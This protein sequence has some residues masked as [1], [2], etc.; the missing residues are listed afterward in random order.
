[1][2]TIGRLEVANFTQWG[3]VADPRIQ[4]VSTVLPLAD[5]M[6]GPNTPTNGLIVEDPLNDLVDRRI[7]WYPYGD[8]YAS[9]YYKRIIIKAKVALNGGVL[10]ATRADDRIYGYYGGDF[11]TAKNARILNIKYSVNPS[12]ENTPWTLHPALNTG[13]ALYNSIFRAD[14]KVKTSDGRNTTLS[15]ACNIQEGYKRQGKSTIGDTIISLPETQTVA[16]TILDFGD[17]NSVAPLWSTYCGIYPE[18]NTRLFPAASRVYEDQADTWIMRCFFE[19][20]SNERYVYFWIVVGP[21]FCCKEDTPPTDTYARRHW[22]LDTSNRPS[23]R[24]RPFETE[25]WGTDA[26]KVRIYGP[27]AC[28]FNGEYSVDSTSESGSAGNWVTTIN[29]VD[30]TQTAAKQQWI[31]F[32][33][34]HAIMGCLFFDD[35]NFTLTDS[36]QAVHEALFNGTPGLPQDS[37]VGVGVSGPTKRGWLEHQLACG[38][39]G[40]VADIPGS[41]EGPPTSLFG[42]WINGDYDV[43]HVNACNIAH[44][45]VINQQNNDPYAY[46]RMFQK[47]CT[48]DQGQF[49]ASRFWHLFSTGI[50]DTREILLSAPQNFTIRGTCYMEEDG[51]IWN[52]KNHNTCSTIAAGNR[53]IRP[54]GTP[55]GDID[56]AQKLSCVVLNAAD[57]VNLGVPMYQHSLDGFGRVRRQAWPNNTGPRTR[58]TNI[59]GTPWAEYGNSHRMSTPVI[60]AAQLCGDPLTRFIIIPAFT[61]S[62]LTCRSPVDRHGYDALGNASSVKGWIVYG[63]NREEGRFFESVASV[64]YL[65]GDPDILQALSRR[66]NDMY[67]SDRGPEYCGTATIQGDWPRGGTFGYRRYKYDDGDEEIDIGGL[68]MGDESHGGDPYHFPDPD[69]YHD[70]YLPVHN[71]WQECY[72]TYGWWALLN[73]L[74]HSYIDPSYEHYSNLMS[75]KTNIQGILGHFIRGQCLH[76][77]FITPPDTGVYKI[78]HFQFVRWA[79]PPGDTTGTPPPRG[80]QRGR[81]PVGKAIPASHIAAFVETQDVFTESAPDGWENIDSGCAYYGLG[82]PYRRIGGYALQW[83]W[84]VWMIGYELGVETGDQELVERCRAMLDMHNP[85][86]R[87]PFSGFTQ[88]ASAGWGFG[89]GFTSGNGERNPTTM[90]SVVT[91]PFRDRGNVTQIALSGDYAGVTDITGDLFR[92][93]IFGD[94]VGETNITGDL[95]AQSDEPIWGGVLNMPYGA[96]AGSTTMAG[97]LRKALDINIPSGTYAGLTTITGNV[98]DSPDIELSGS[99]AGV[100]T[101]TGTLVSEEPDYGQVFSLK[102]ELR[103]EHGFRTEYPMVAVDQ[104]AQ[105]WAGNDFTLKYSVFD[106]SGSPK[107]LSGA[108]IDWVMQKSVSD[109]DQQI[110]KSLGSGI[111]LA[112]TDSNEIRI[113]L[114]GSDTTGYSGRYYSELEVELSGIET[115]IAT[116]WIDIVPTAID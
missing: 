56:I 74:K 98:Q 18:S 48:T 52:A 70:L 103:T 50:P 87:F 9:G 12:T 59:S 14:A 94:Y 97:D 34:Q 110:V 60:M 23:P 108:T 55:P 112:G 53:G 80:G 49:N 109:T 68:A 76:L 27:R 95:V 26:L 113:T 106:A 115:T 13:A 40:S 73:A 33:Q 24:Y 32:G 54:T 3:T 19:V 63:H 1:M 79:W 16:A 35:P 57:K 114:D 15:G 100:S 77:S 102:G 29:I 83:A 42:T 7:D 116:G 6:V 93:G 84:G 39:Y 31:R 105:I 75:A 96:Y 89:D 11:S 10:R 78:C 30:A 20:P 104:N 28:I 66:V 61:S 82:V 46:S 38:P 101:I 4:H 25:L 58:A 22:Q 71:P 41:P 62:S 64:Y 36:E 21:G 8:R 88:S 5:G 2:T 17:A 107:N 99:Y 72:L 43:A 37:M 44:E 90:G 51:T 47:E 91:K 45:G 92:Q 69:G 81:F 67:M 86:S 111:T 85:N 65:S